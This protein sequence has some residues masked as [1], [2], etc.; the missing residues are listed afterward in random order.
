MPKSWLIGA[1]IGGTKCDW[2]HGGWMG[3]VTVGKRRQER[4]DEEGN[5]ERG[6]LKVE[7]DEGSEQTGFPLTGQRPGL[8]YQRASDK[9]INIDRTHRWTDNS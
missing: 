9:Y 7:G 1:Q 2:T 6:I 8:C 3:R 4:R 5:E